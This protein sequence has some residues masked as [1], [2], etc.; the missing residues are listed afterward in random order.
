MFHMT[1]DSGLFKTMPELEAEG[2]YPVEG[3][4]WRKGE[5]EC[6]PLYEGRMVQRY[7]HR[8]ASIELHPENVHRPAQPVSAAEAE[9]RDPRWLP[10]AQYWVEEDR[11]ERPLGLGWCVGFK[12]V[13][14]PT[15]VRT[16]LAAA[17]P[18]QGLGNTLPVFFPERGAA[19]GAYRTSA[20]LLLAHLNAFAFDYL[21]R[22]K[23]QGQHLNLYIVEQ[24]PVVPAESFD[25]TLGDRSIGEF[26][27]GEVLRLS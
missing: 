8:A 15:N 27:R 12:D 23:V 9:H 7:D 13:T 10:E 25:E 14:A 2:W 16:M 1:N 17:L 20:P 19:L 26:V 22:Q 11:V 5:A 3:N 24:I 6:V 4:R 18:L 21:A